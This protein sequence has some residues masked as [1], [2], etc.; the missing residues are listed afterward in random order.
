MIDRAGHRPPTTPAAFDRLP[1]AVLERLLPLATHLDFPFGALV[2]REG[3]ESPFLGLVETGRVA[4]RL[5]VPE[6]GERL[7]IVT[8]EPGDL[9][10]WS[11]VVAPYRA[12]VEAVATEPARILAFEATA[13]RECLATDA[14]LAA[15][16]LPVV[17]ESVSHR[18]TTSW[19]QLLDLFGAQAPE[20]W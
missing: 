15:A 17:L 6:R 11:A 13:L 8:V 18:L 10:G 7:T 1:P 9:L 19:N 4:L 2:L 16:L 12:T 14:E 3:A 5:R 20:P